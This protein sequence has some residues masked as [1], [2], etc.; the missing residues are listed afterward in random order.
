MGSDPS[1][2]REIHMDD[3]RCYVVGYSGRNSHEPKMIAK[4]FAIV[5]RSE[6]DFHDVDGA[7]SWTSAIQK[8][9]KRLPNID[10]NGTAEEW[11][12]QLKLGSSKVRFEDLLLQ[13]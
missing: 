8:V 5:L 10:L 11:L 4:E 6:P 13:K 1:K 3:G 9:R 12:E 2:P 7:C